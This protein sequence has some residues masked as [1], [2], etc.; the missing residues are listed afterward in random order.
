M[1]LSQNDIYVADGN[2]SVIYY[3]NILLHT[4]KLVVT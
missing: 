1:H 2:H 3:N 4:L